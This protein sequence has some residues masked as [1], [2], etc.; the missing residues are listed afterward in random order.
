MKKKEDGIADFVVCVPVSEPIPGGVVKGSTQEACGFCGQAVWIAPASRA[1]AGTAPR[2][3]ATCF[4]D[5]FDGE[6]ART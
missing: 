3:C 4:M 1:L 2:I 5:R 6:W